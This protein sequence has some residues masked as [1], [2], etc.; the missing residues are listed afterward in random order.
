M[1]A[2]IEK[3]QTITQR[4]ANTGTTDYIGE[5]LSQLEHSL[6]SAYFAEKAHHCEEVILA[7][8]LHDL[9]HFYSSTSQF[10][11]ADLGIVH[12]EWIGAKI[13]YDLHF[14]RKVALLIGYH[15]DAKRYLAGKKPQYYQKLS[16]ASQQTLAFQGGL[17]TSEEM[18]DFER[19]PLFK[20]ILQVRAN[21]EKA[22]VINLEVPGLDYYKMMIYEH[23]A[24]EQ[25]VRSQAHESF[26]LRD[27]V[28][29]QWVDAFK[30]YLEVH[31]G[32]ETIG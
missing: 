10:K 24:H 26:E 7:S 20:E 27:F 23:I 1:S 25:Q 5:P 3:I 17:M 28:D 16:N 32:S 29:K 13:A 2:I 21:D 11:M 31:N 22:K 30:I 12:H 15:V 8:L 6:Q 14:S 4:L 18:Q 9:G 19:L